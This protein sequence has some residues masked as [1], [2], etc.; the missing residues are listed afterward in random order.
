MFPSSSSM[1][2]KDAYNVE[3]RE[4]SHRGVHESSG[5]TE[6]KQNATSF[7]AITFNNNM[8]Q[9][10][11]NNN[12]F[13]GG[14]GSNINRGHNPNLNCKHCGKISHTID[15]CF[16][17]V[18]FPQGFKMNSNIGKQTFNAN[19][20]VKMNDKPSS[21]SLSYGFTPEQMQ[22]SM[23]NDK[24]S[25]SIHA[26]MTGM[27]IAKIARKRSKPDKHGHGNGRAYKEPG[28]STK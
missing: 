14:S 4:E 13:T 7:V 27:D 21:F 24:P 18:G 1:K 23:I 9:F 28:V 8:R 10:N 6:S 11:N 15:R 12:N 20:D 22:L 5:V 25:E 26:N 2:V 16:E 3:S 17:I 19:T